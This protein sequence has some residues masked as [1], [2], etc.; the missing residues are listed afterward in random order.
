MKI[1]RI[2]IMRKSMEQHGNA[3]VET[4]AESKEKVKSA[5][6][7][8]AEIDALKEGLTDVPADLDDSIT[9]AIQATEQAGREQATNDVN[10]VQEEI[11]QDVA[12]AESIK[13][14]I[15]TKIS[16]NNTA[17]STL[18]SLKSNKYGG[19]IDRATS[20]IEANNAVGESIKSNLDAEYQAINSEIEAARN[21][22]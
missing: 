20:E 3:S 1:R 7:M 17:K 10:E 18:E 22:I 5:Q 19:G 6:E 8:R 15:D 16:E 21:G 13:G 11:N 2:L 12:K 9:S 14:E 4:I